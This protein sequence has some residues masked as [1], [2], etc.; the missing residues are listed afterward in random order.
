MYSEKVRQSA[1]E[2]VVA[3]GQTPER[4]AM[5]IGATTK[6]VYNWVNAWQSEHRNDPDDKLEMRMDAMWRQAFQ[7]LQE[8]DPATGL[9]FLQPILTRTIPEAQPDIV[10]PTIEALKALRAGWDAE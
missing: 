6:T 9:K 8:A 1:V 10:D 4:V 7:F 5:D 2:R 3:M